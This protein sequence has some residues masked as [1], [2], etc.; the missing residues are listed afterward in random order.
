MKELQEYAQG[1]P[2]YLSEAVWQKCV[3]TLI[4]LYSELSASVHG[5]RVTELEF[6]RYLCDIKFMHKDVVKE[7]LLVGKTVV[8][9]NTLLT[10]F[11]HPQFL[12]FPIE[13]R[14]A[15]L[16]SLPS[17]TRGMVSTR[18]IQPSNG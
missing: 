15:I 18:E 11:Y 5:Q 9:I 10:I 2:D 1:H 12:A 13:D 17:P 7:S 14:R 4:S 8:A 3:E 6:R 16:R